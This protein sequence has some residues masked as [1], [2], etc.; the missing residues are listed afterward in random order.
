MEQIFISKEAKFYLRHNKRD[1]ATTIF[2][3]VRLCGKQF[4]LS[5]SVKVI[6][7]QWNQREQIAY[8]S[9]RLCEL[10]NHNNEIVNSRL[11]VIKERYSDFIKHICENPQKALNCNEL[12]R[13]YIYVDNMTKK[14]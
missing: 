2:M 7:T 5:T 11:N 1:K 10:D 14:Q 3:M 9:H 12:L 4:K 6:P 8:I 13:R